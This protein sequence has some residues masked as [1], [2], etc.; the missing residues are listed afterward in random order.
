MN[1]AQLLLP[2]SIY[3]PYSFVMYAII[4]NEQKLFNN[5][6]EQMNKNSPPSTYNLFGF[7]QKPR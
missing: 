4:N 7:I 3:R 6:Q 2:K 5:E 1:K